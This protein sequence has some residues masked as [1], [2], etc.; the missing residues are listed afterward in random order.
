MS[1]GTQRR[2]HTYSERHAYKIS[3]LVTHS[4]VITGTHRHRCALTYHSGAFM[5]PQKHV[6]VHTHTRIHANL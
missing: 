2:T 6:C 1:L 3:L 5:S 4:Q